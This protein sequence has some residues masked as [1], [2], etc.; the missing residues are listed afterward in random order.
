M[1]L[2][3]LCAEKPL[4]NLLE[5]GGDGGGRLESRFALDVRNTTRCSAARYYALDFTKSME[6]LKW[7]NLGPVFEPGRDS[8]D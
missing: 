7:Q 2:E 4:L 8:K 1:G 3:A 6:A 5:S